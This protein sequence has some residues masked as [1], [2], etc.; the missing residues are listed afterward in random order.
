MSWVHESS[1]GR[2]TVRDVFGGT[3]DRVI[4]VASARNTYGVVI[5][6]DFPI[7]LRSNI[8]VAPQLRFHYVNRADLGDGSEIVGPA[9]SSCGPQS[10]SGLDSQIPDRRAARAAAD[11]G[12]RRLRSRS[13][14]AFWRRDRDR[15]TGS[16][17]RSIAVQD[18]LEIRAHVIASA[19]A[20]TGRRAPRMRRHV[21]PSLSRHRPSSRPL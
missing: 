6:W 2:R 11:G 8:L 1:V 9:R 15:S 4:A 7:S 19:D 21:R 13:T 20:G 16:A 3:A 10:P 12:G 18:G 14:Q 17:R 5:G